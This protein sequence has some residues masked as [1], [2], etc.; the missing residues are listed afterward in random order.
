MSLVKN[1][2]MIETLAANA[3]NHPFDIRILPRRARRRP[4]LVD[5][6]SFDAPDEVRTID[7]IAVPQQIVRRGFPWKGVDDL[8]RRPLSTRVVGDVEVNDTAAIVTK[9]DEDEQNPERGS[10][11]GERDSQG[12]A[13]GAS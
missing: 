10:R 13:I 1:D 5:A 6:E 7:A 11:Q 3:T 4:N 8:L 12:Q 9:D 2:H